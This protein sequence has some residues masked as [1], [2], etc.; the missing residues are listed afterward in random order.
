MRHRPSALVLGGGV[1]KEVGEDPEAVALIG[2]SQPADLASLV[3][4]P[5]A[6]RV[7]AQKMFDSPSTAPEEHAS[8]Q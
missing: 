6:V 2:L 8:S 1:D 3:G 7:G 5:R 4:D